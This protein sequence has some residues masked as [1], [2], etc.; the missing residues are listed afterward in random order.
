MW[1]GA[2]QRV[3]LSHASPNS[4]LAGLALLSSPVNRR[5]TSTLSPLPSSPHRPGEVWTGWTKQAADEPIHSSG[6]QIMPGR[7]MGFY[8]SLLNPQAIER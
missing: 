7:T 2:R 3:R 8:Y 4:S 1:R 5:F 6:M